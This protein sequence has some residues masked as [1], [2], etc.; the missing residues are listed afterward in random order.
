VVAAAQT[1]KL[2]GL[3]VQ[4]VEET[5][6]HRQMLREPQVLQIQVAVAAGDG[7]LLLRPVELTEVRE[8]LLF[9]I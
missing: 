2:L 5:E 6:E 9:D 4:E 3:A 1:I 8:L 7:I